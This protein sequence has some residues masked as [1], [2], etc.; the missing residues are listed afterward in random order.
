MST[1]FTYALIL[2]V[3][4]AIFNLLMYFAGFQ[5]E[6]IATGQYFQWLGFVFIAVVLWLGIRA[7]REEAPGQHLS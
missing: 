1:K 7:L 5:T 4:Q 3:V 6:R 2:T